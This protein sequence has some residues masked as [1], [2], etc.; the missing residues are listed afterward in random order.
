MS[1]TT[2]P[3]Q[4]QILAAVREAEQR[5]LPAKLS[6]PAKVGVNGHLIANYL[7]KTRLPPTTENFYQ[8]FKALMEKLEWTVKPAKLVLME[9]QD[10]PAKA[11]SSV[12]LIEQ[13]AKVVKDAEIADAYAKQ[14]SDYEQTALTLI[15]SFL[16]YNK[17]GS[18]DYRKREEVQTQ[19]KKHLASEKVRGCS[20]KAVHGVIAAHILKEYEKIEKANER[21]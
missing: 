15:D 5:L 11:E 8:A 6:D 9:K 2:V 20:M 17:R 21:M 12:E 13:R 7:K 1:T 10:A 14:Q 3:T 16:P 19:L 4:Q 18:I